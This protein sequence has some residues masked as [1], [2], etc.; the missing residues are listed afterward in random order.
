MAGGLA[1]NVTV[2]ILLVVDLVLSSIHM[3]QV[4]S[5]KKKSSFG[6]L[7]T[8]IQIFVLSE[9]VEIMVPV[10]YTSCFMLAYFGPNAKVLGNIQNNYF[11]YNA[12]DDVWNSFKNLCIIMIIDIFFFTISI[13]ALF[14]FCSINIFKVIFKINNVFL[15]IS[16]T[17][18]NH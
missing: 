4:I 16:D 15:K 14:K 6:S 12:V 10:M 8:A 9:T 2:Y 1:T 13:F 18:M 5:L 7:S 17:F 3:L 11:H